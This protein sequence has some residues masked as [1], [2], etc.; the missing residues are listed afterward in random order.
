[1][2]TFE[3]INE[4]HPIITTNKVASKTSINFILKRSMLND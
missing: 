1:M 2:E 3:K 4:F